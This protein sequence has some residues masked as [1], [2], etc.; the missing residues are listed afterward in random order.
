MSV[1]MDRLRQ[2]IAAGGHDYWLRDAR[3]P[4]TLIPGAMPGPVDG[5]GLVRFDLKIEQGRIAA[6]AP[7]GTAI[8]GPSLD[9][10][11]VWPGPVDGHTHLDKGHIWPRHENAT[12]SFHGALTACATDRNVLD[13]RGHR[14]ALRVEPACRLCAR[15]G[16][17][18][19]ASR[20]LCAAR[21]GFLAGLPHAARPL[22]R[23]DHPTGQLD[24]AARP[25]PGRGWR[26][27]CRIPWPTRAASSAW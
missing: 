7:L 21:S 12:G 14:G 2:A 1:A 6:L 20:K 8:E 5:Q 10:G 3:A 17:H 26:A 25:L 13:R 19:H 11:Q 18:P 9:G 24:R 4:A 27:A 22:G 16:R 23:A 15:H